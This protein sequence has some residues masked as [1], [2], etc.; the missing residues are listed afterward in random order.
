M[1]ADP[2]GR[3]FFII[4]VNKIVPGNA[5]LAPAIIGR[6]QSEMQQAVSEDYARQFLAAIRKEVGARRN[7]GAIQALK[8]RMRNNGG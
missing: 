7:D 8:N 2:Q 6:M 5:L 3:G 1:Q 4:K